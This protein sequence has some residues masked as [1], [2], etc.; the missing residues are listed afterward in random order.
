MVNEK[1]RAFIY[2]R[3][4]N[5]ANNRFAMVSQSL[6]IPMEQG[7]Q[8]YVLLYEGALKGGGISHI[9]TNLNGH[10]IANKVPENAENIVL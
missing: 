7:D 10:K 8:F 5:G 3:D 9:F 1:P 6:M 4:V 2:D